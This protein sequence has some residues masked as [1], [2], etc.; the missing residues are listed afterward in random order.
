M[1]WTSFIKKLIALDVFWG[2]RSKIFHGIKDGGAYADSLGDP[3]RAIKVAG[4]TIFNINN[5]SNEFQGGHYH[6][7]SIT[8]EAESVFLQGLI[9]RTIDAVGNWVV[10]VSDNT[11]NKVTD[12]TQGHVIGV[13]IAKPSTTTCDVV[14]YGRA[15]VFSGLDSTQKRYFLSAA[16]GLT[17]TP[18]TKGYVLELGKALNSTTLQVHIT[19]PMIRHPF[20]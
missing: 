11:V 17:A 16:G 8:S 4:R 6:D 7:T 3:T 5:V 20:T 1:T 14:T 13:I 18:P 19:T 2:R 12:N 10:I 15:A 9:C